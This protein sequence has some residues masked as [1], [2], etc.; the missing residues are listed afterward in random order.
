MARDKV[1]FQNADGVTLSGILERPEGPVA[2][3]ALFAHCF[4]C[5]KNTLAA[6][7]LGEGLAERGFGV[8]R[9]DFTGLG[10]S[11]GDFADTGFTTNVQDLKAAVAWMEAQGM[12]VQLMIGH[13]LG[14]AAAVVAASELSEIR[15][16]VTLG[17]PADAEHVVHQFD[18]HIPEIEAK[19]AAQVDIAG[20][21]FVVGEAFLESVRG[22]K[23]KEAAAKLKRPLL[24]MHAPRDEI[25]SIDNAT[26]LF[27]AAKHPKSFVSLDQAGHMLSNRADT[28][29]V[30][31][32]ILAWARRYLGAQGAAPAAA[33]N[34]VVR[35]RETG[36]AGAYQNSV[37]IDGRLFLADEPKS[38]GGADTGPNPYQWVSAGLGACTSI[39]L[40]MYANRKKWPLENV[41]VDLTHSRQHHV[42]CETCGPNDKIDVFTREITLD[43]PLDEAQKQRLLEIADRCPVHRT[44]ENEAKVETRLVTQ[45]A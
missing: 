7:R 30:A 35:V 34:D 27:V 44:L 23:V 33:R 10:Q 41:T 43:G 21:P 16:V 9:F 25:V 4:T 19:G 2:A 12:P 29:Y 17:A 18:Q 13:S 5:S 32:V 6:S 8:L 14:G 42:D 38:I 45:S 22:A 36:Q 31:E 20:R 26:G 11:D 15:A 24:V 40:R 28:D 1:S 3:W 37:E 39:T